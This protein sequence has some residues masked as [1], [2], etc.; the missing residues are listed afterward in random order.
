MNDVLQDAVKVINLIKNH[1][2]NSRLFSNLCK[3]TDSNYT[4]LLLHAEVRWLSRGQSLK[5]L[6][7]LKDE[8]EI[9]LTERKCEFAAFF[10]NDLWLSKLC[11]LSDIF[12]KLNDLNLSL[13]GKNCDIFTSN[14]KI[15]SFIKKISIWKSRVEKNSFEMFSSVD[16]FVIEKI[17]RKTFIAKTIV[18]H[19]KALEIQ[20]R[21][22]F[23]LNIDLQKIVWI[24]K[25]FW[26]GL[27]EIDH[28]PLK[29]QEEFAELSCDSNLKLQFQKKPLTEFWIGTRTEFPTIADMALNVL[30]PFNT[31]Y[32][33]E[34]T[35]SALTHIKSQYRSAIKNVEEVLRPA[36]SNITPRFDLLCNKK[37]AHPSH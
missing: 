17:H 25:P 32:L 9:F 20:F 27:S 28:L 4:T 33:C 18:D 36:V 15:E 12:A 22:Y 8:I 16:N 1:A 2:L 23:I 37:Q 24:Q 7:L 35:F 14:D 6:L 10:Q 26:I 29:A 31:T 34:V 19:L 5:R 3:D 30:L 21:T 11:Y 13:Q